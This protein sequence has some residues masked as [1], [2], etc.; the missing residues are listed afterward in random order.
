MSE[1]IGAWLKKARTDAGMTQNALANLLDGI[2]AADISKAERG[3]TQLLPEQLQ[4]ITAALGIAPE[5]PA[6]P[7][8][9]EA[10][11]EPA[12]QPAAPAADTAEL[13]DL[14]RQAD[15]GTR[16]AVLVLLKGEMDYKPIL[17]SVAGS[18]MKNLTLGGGPIAGILNNVQQLFN[19]ASDGADNPLVTILNGLTGI[20]GGVMSMKASFTKEKAEKAAGE[21]AE[22][23]ECAK[24]ADTGAKAAPAAGEKAVSPAIEKVASGPLLGFT[25]SY[26]VVIYLLLISFYFWLLRTDIT[27]QDE[28]K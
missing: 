3:L 15:P 28:G 9:E 8:A 11:Q 27:P 18:L 23:R 26:S 22:T 21:K 19:P 13:L 14:Y 25:F 4:S 1:D 16:D 24:P 20:V 17:M 2:T 7:P 6:A 12:P 5:A 10:A